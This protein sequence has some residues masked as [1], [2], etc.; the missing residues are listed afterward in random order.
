MPDAKPTDA[1]CVYLDNILG[2][3]THIGP[4]LF[5]LSGPGPVVTGRACLRR[6]WIRQVGATPGCR[7]A[8]VIDYSIRERGRAAIG[9]QP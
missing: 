4:C 6:G 5:Q 8:D 2:A 7:G 9:K 1:Q 3:E